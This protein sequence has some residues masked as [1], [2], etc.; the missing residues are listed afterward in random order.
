MSVHNNILF[1]KIRMGVGLGIMVI[2]WIAYFAYNMQSTFTDILWICFTLYA[3][4]A[5]LYIPIKRIRLLQDGKT[6]R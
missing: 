5:Y 4:V 2:A 3:L 6:K 1:W